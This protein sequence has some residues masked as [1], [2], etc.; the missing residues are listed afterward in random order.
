MQLPNYPVDRVPWCLMQTLPFADPGTAPLSGPWALLRWIGRQQWPTLLAGMLWGGCWMLAQAIIPIAVGRS[1][2]QLLDQDRAGAQ[3]WAALVLALAL[4]Q[5]LTGTLRHRAAVA[6]WLQATFRLSQLM[7]RH[8]CTNAGVVTRSISTGEVVT[9][10]T[11]DALAVGSAFDVTARFTGAVLSYALVAVVILNISPTLG[12]IILFGVPL[13][14]GTLGLLV[15]PLHRRQAEQRRQAGNLTTL[16]ADIVSGL[17][18]L[19]GLGGERIFADRYRDQSQK[20]QQKSVRVAA[21]EAPLASAELLLPGLL[22]VL[23]TWLGGRMV[24]RGELTIGELVQC[25]GLTIFLVTPLRTAGEMLDRLTRAHVGAARA[26]SVLKINPDIVER[27]V[28]RQRGTRFDLDPELPLIDP[29]TNIQITA[30][31]LT[32]VVSHDSDELRELAQRLGRLR[33]DPAAPIFL[34]DQRID[35]IPL[36]AL[37]RYI[38]VSESIPQLFS[39]SVRDQLLGTDQPEA[40]SRLAAAIHSCAAEDISAALPKGL[41]SDLSERGRSLSGGQRQRLVLARAL[42]TEAPILILVEPTSAV[43]AH[44]EALI[45][46]RLAAHRRGKTT[47]LMTTSP[48]LLQHSDHA[49]LLRDG[50]LLAQGTHRELL[51]RTDYQETVLRVAHE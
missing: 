50:K 20:V 11:H 18:V 47:V 33:D 23:L 28:P 44:T 30:G 39:G 25:Y 31:R 7:S 49:I 34:G 13:L 51:G 15:G 1:I 40:D 12:L 8:V 6:N 4:F 9:S 2:D 32:A 21:I 10:V 16:G 36:A 24:I 48:L 17:R 14:T 37:R 27:T 5:A 45:G 43:D 46:A 22:M 35:F 19:R 3:R 42:L 29:A 26:L 38:V 41:S